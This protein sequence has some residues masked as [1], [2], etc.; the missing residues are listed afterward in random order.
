MN[1]H[2]IGI[3]VTDMEKTTELFQTFG[4]V[5]DETKTDLLQNV[6]VRFLR[7]MTGPFIELISDG[8]GK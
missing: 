8:E 7:R 5:A 4:Y 6:S 1:L 2:H 3:A